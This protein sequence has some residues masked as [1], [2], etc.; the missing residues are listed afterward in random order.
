MIK[1]TGLIL[2]A[3][4]ALGSLCGATAASVAKANADAAKGVPTVVKARQVTGASLPFWLSRDYTGG[5]VINTPISAIVMQR[6]AAERRPQQPAEL[7]PQALTSA[8][9]W[10]AAPP[11]AKRRRWVCTQSPQLKAEHLPRLLR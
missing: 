3:A 7:S 11:G 9:V 1:F 6:Q 2:S 4:V 10:Q 5:T 8:D